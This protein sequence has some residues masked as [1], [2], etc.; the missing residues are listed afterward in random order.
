MP[1]AVSYLW[2]WFLEI[3]MGLASNGMGVPIVTWESL[4]AW[5]CQ[6]GVD[7]DPW[8]ARALV[9]LGSLRAEI[10]AEKKPTPPGRK[11]P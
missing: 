2:A 8:E 3:A 10:L 6:M 5:R 11:K 1:E 9:R 7:L 4:F